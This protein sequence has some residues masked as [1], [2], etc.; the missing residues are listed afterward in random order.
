MNI[1]VISIDIL[2]LY[3][4]SDTGDV[5]QPISPAERDKAPTRVV[6]TEQEI[7][8]LTTQEWQSHWRQQE[9]Y[10][11]LLERKAAQQEGTS[12]V[13]NRNSVLMGVT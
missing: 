4:M 12:S 13:I 10:A 1:F 5:Q 9:S 2:L 11:I 3:R 6:M 7:N 8:A